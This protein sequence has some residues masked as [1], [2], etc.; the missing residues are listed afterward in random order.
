MSMLRSCSRAA[1]CGN[2]TGARHA[3]LL[4]DL[5]RAVGDCFSMLSSAPTGQV[6]TV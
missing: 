2:V 3:P 4:K 6:S 1:A 5:D